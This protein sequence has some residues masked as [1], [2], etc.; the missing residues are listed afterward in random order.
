[1]DVVRIKES[2]KEK[3]IVKKYACKSFNAKN[4]Q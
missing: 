3:I 1:M 2:I 4:F